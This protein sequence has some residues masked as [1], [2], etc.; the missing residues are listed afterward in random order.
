MDKN[1]FNKKFKKLSLKKNIKINSFLSYTKTLKGDKDKEEAG[2]IKRNARTK[3]FF[4]TPTLNSLKLS[5]KKL[6]QKFLQ[7]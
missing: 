5:N 2:A 1:I 7:L 3:G 6:I 4:Q